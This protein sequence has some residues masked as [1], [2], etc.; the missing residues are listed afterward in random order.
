V[1]TGW[2][3]AVVTSPPKSALCHAPCHIFSDFSFQN[4]FPEYLG[5]LQNLISSSSKFF[6]FGFFIGYQISG[7]Y[8]K[9]R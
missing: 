8:K 7:Y 1:T 3:A 9:N 5:R 6:C 4:S 2:R